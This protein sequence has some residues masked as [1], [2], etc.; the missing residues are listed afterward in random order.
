MESNWRMNV[1][2]LGYTQTGQRLIAR[3]LGTVFPDLYLIDNNRADPHAFVG[4]FVSDTLTSV[5]Y[6]N[7]TFGA[8]LKPAGAGSGFPY[9]LEVEDD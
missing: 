5:Y 2:R 4:F 8:G 9:G 1:W 7:N 3:V 6:F